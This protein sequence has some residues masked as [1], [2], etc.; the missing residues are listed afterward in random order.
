[1]AQECKIDS[2]DLFDM[3]N[4]P[5]IDVKKVVGGKT[6]RTCIHRKR[7]AQMNIRQK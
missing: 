5:P 1:M 7:F 3:L 6:C 4:V 2:M